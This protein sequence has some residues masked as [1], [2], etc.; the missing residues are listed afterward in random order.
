MKGLKGSLARQIVFMYAGLALFVFLVTISAIAIAEYSR[1]MTIVQA[2]QHQTKAL[3]STRIHSEALTLTNGI[4]LYITTSWNKE[5][6]RRALD[7][8]ITLLEDLL[9]QASDTVDPNNVDE[10]FALGDIRQYLI[11]FNLQSKNVLNTFDKEKVYGEKTQHQM[12][13]LLNNYQPSLI[14]SLKYFSEFES[15][16]SN[17][18]FNQA[19]RNITQAIIWLL[20]LSAIAIASVIFMTNQVI[21]KFAQPLTVLT[22]NV[23]NLPNT[24]LNIPIP[25]KSNDEIGELTTAINSMAKEV[26]TSRQQLEE[27]AATLETQVKERTQQFQ[28]AKNTA[29]NA[30]T[31]L[32]TVLNN[33]DA[34][35][36]VGDMQTGEILFANQPILDEFGDIQGKI[37]WQSLYTNK[38]SPCDFCTNH[39]LLDEDGKATDVVRQEEQD[40]LTGRWY[41]TM[42]SAVQWID[43][44]LVRLAARLDIT[45]V[46]EAEQ[47]LLTHEREETREKERRRLARDL[48]DTLT[49]SLHSLVLMADTSQRLLKNEQYTA[50]PEPIQLLEDSARQSLREMR[51]LLHELQLSEDEQIDLEEALSTRL[52]IVEQRVGI[53][54]EL[55]INGQNYLPSTF[56]KEIFYIAVEALN[57]SIKHSHADHIFVSI[58]ASPAEIEM[59]IKDNGRGFDT[60]PSGNHGMGLENIQFRAEKLN[61]TLHITSNPGEGTSIRLHIVQEHISPPLLNT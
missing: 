50:L 60:T 56:S 1:Q 51:L 22:E 41:S 18:A 32:E 21:K 24:S 44:R 54:T 6:Q 10:S 38:L 2:R 12:G 20:L 15:D 46:K 53:K 59:L 7:A 57:N 25:I 31:L 39:L 48:H 17:T 47:V 13:A 45:D 3:L 55:E 27:Y 23:K 28:E 43:G 34:H 4:Q 37:C 58:Q 30:R 8:Q 61:G 42:S 40:N 49:Q 14:N 16:A 19:E 52:R 36:Y 9:E 26:N 11:S 35:I 5:S 33:I 29:E